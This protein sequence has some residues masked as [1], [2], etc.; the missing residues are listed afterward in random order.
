MNACVRLAGELPSMQKCLFRNL[1]AL[2][3]AIAVLLRDHVP[4]R[5]N[6]EARGMLFWRC[7]GGTL[8][9]ICNFYAIDHLLLANASMLQKMAPFFAVVFS[10]FL[11]REKP[12][13][14][15][16][17]CVLAAF[18]GSL[19]IV[20]PS[21]SGIDLPA[22]VGLVGGVMG[23][24]AYTCVRVLTSRY[25]VKNAVIIFWFCVF[26]TAVTLP[27]TLLH[28]Q[29]MTGRQLLFLLL[30]GIAATCGQFGV[31]AAYSYAPAKE[32]S[33]Y[34]YSQILFSALFGYVLYQ[35]IP[36][37]YSVLGYAVI[38]GASLLMFF[39]NAE[40]RAREQGA[41]THE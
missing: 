6:R 31:T 37:A 30:A 5:V 41:G 29:P 17:L 35:Q 33:V 23:G 26:S 32:I 1:I 22:L 9:L 4:L 10:A 39:Y 25:H 13:P 16:L 27:P 28:Y 20:K 11:L 15:Q 14:V 38:F 7:F 19:F 3:I 40:K 36:D 18:A 24:F 8:G 12:A 34:D 2:F 21:F